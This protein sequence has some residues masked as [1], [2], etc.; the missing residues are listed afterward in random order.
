MSKLSNINK[1]VKRVL[2]IPR[3][4]ARENSKNNSNSIWWN[5]N[6]KF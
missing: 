2:E 5:V 4:V 1:K 6:W 3:E